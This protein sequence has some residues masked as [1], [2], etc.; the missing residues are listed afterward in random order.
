[1]KKAMCWLFLVL[2]LCAAAVIASAATLEEEEEALVAAE[3]LDQQLEILN[4]IADDYARDLEDSWEITPTI[5]SEAQHMPEGIVPDDWEEYG[6]EVTDG[7]PEELRSHKFIV[8]NSNGSLAATF[9][10]RLPAEMRAAT[11]EEAEY[12]V[13]V[14]SVLTPSGYNYIP[15]ASSSHRDYMA[16]ALNLKTGE[17]VRFWF[18]RN[19]AKHSGKWGE[20]NGDIMSPEEIWKNLRAQIMSDIRYPLD[21]GSVLI[22]GVTGR[23]CYLKGYEGEPVD[24]EIPAAP[25][26]YPVTEIGEK[27]FYSCETLKRVIIPES[28]KTISA[29][30][31]ELCTILEEVSLPSTLEEIARDAFRGCHSLKDVSFPEGL[32]SIGAYAFYTTGLREIELP[33]SMEVTDHHAFSSCNNLRRAVVRYAITFQEEEIFK[34]D[35]NLMCVYMADGA[36]NSYAL[37]GIPS[38]TVI[39]ASE[40]SYYLEWARESGRQAE[41]C[42]KPEDM[43]PVEYIIEDGMEFVLFNGE[44]GLCG[45]MGEA[46][47]VTVPETAGGVPVTRIMYHAVY[48][49]EHVTGITIPSGVREIT[50]SAIYAVGGPVPMDIY[51]ANPD[52]SIVE[53]AIGRYGTNNTPVTIHAPEGSTAQRYVIDTTDEPLVFE[54]WGEGANPDA[55]FLQNAAI[56]AGDVQR[57]VSEFWDSCDREEYSW[58]E[59]I[60]GYEIEKP[61]AAA[62]L[63]M[64]REQFNSLT[65]LMTGPENTAK[66][67][68]LIVNTQWNLPYARAAVQTAQSGQFSPVPDGSCA[69]AVLAYRNDLVLVTVDESGAA[70]AALLCSSP[71]VTGSITPEYI[72]GIAARYGVSGECAVYSGEE[73]EA[74]LSGSSDS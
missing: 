45:Y 12:A 26:G 20:L 16:F 35:K 60:P 41:A 58:L 61:A 1:M 32:R 5:P 56:L 34:D 14:R 33:E 21:N 73:T 23:N 48:C 50:G 63:R 31:F 67:F 18:Q 2:L 46:A 24:V 59:R 43:P 68:S 25:E 13:V 69:V 4:R 49:L 17:A 55:G 62:V 9:F 71:A 27:C 7:F 57:A 52:I 72:T 54:P 29:S 3:T 40:G 53:R 38:N 39:Y 42:E 6:Y 15:P 70:E 22:F 36:S 66:V 51:I 30:A 47:T 8:L 65:K 74:L 37:S 10:C 28:T 11:M 64:T 19:G 44:A